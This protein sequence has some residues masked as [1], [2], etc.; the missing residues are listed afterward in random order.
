MAIGVVITPLATTLIVTMLLAPRR[1]DLDEESLAKFGVLGFALAIALAYTGALTQV[2]TRS[3]LIRAMAIG[4]GG[5]AWAGAALLAFIFLVI[6]ER[7]YRFDTFILCMIA[8]GVLFLL[9]LT[10]TI[11]VPIAVVSKASKVRQV[12]ESLDPRVRV[13][14]GC[15]KCSERQTHRPGVL[16][17]VS[18][19][20]GLFLEI[21]EP[22]CECGYLLYQ[23][24][25]NTC[26]ECGRAV[27]RSRGDDAG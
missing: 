21:E 8:L 24:T 15:P 5:C 27:A 20:T 7:S 25:G 4:T 26:P 11:A 22:R 18:C 12:S 10:G 19:G 3:W 1:L 16:K 14:F 6:A 23:L 13:H 17:C 2:R 9:M